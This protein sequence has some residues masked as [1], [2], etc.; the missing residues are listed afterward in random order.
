M[1]IFLCVAA[2]KDPLAR[3]IFNTAVV[4]FLTG[5]WH[6]ASWNFIL[7][8]SLYGVLIIIEKLVTTALTKAGKQDIFTK[9]PSIIK[10]CLCDRP[11]HACMG[12]L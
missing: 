3:T 2:V 4:W 11:R 8:G 1:S 7:W 5:V 10:T 9:I 12:T 6:G